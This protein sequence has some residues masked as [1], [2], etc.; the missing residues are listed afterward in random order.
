MFQS[1]RKL[2]LW[3][4]YGL[5]N[6]G[7]FS[8]AVARQIISLYNDCS[9]LSVVKSHSAHNLS[10]RCRSADSHKTYN[11]IDNAEHTKHPLVY[12]FQNDLSVSTG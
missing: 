8:F 1:R 11:Y 4:G 10:S 7:F 5:L 9:E 6:D 2:S 3:H 12:P